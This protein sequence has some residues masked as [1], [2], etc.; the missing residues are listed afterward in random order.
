MS[1]I[2]V[3][4]ESIES[5]DRAAAAQLLPL[6][7]EELRRLAAHELHGEPSGNTLQPTALVHEAYVRLVGNEDVPKWNHRGHFYGAAAKA[8][9][10]ILVDSA[11]RK[12]ALKR[13]GDGER[14]PLDDKLLAMADRHEDLLALDAALEK[15]EEQ[16]P[17]LAELVLLRYFAGLTMD[18]AAKSLGLSKRKTERNWTYVRAW[19]LEAMS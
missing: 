17:D 13:G 19:I 3:L 11:R 8:M 12:K 14:L 5:G 9:R 6:V 1:E 7:Y 16:R 15:L 4:L 10:Q 18:Q 2:S